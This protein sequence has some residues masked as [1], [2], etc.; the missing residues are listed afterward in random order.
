ML[1]IGGVV[2]SP[3]PL[4]G[5]RKRTF[6]ERPNSATAGRLNL[7]AVAVTLGCAALNEDLFRSLGRCSQS[8]PGEPTPGLMCACSRC[9]RALGHRRLR[10][11]PPAHTTRPT[12]GT[13]GARAP[14]P[15]LARECLL[16][17]RVQPVHD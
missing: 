5:T 2:R 10:C 8:R 14:L 11:L 9:A 16:R 3:E 6:G 1:V 17:R 12:V 15:A 13:R 4:Q 7:P